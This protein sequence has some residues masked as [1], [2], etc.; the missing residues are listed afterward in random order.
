[1]ARAVRVGCG[2][3]S[4]LAVF[5]YN[6]L[7]SASDACNTARRCMDFT[8]PYATVLLPEPMDYFAGCGRTP[9]CTQK[10][11]QDIRAFEE[12][13]KRFASVPLQTFTMSQQIRESLMF[14]DLNQDAYTPLRIAAMVQLT[15]CTSVCG[16]ANQPFQERNEKQIVEEEERDYTKDT[17][18]AI[19]GVAANNTLIVHKYCIP[20]ALGTGVYRE[21]SETWSVWYSE[22]WAG[23]V[24]DLKFLDSV[25]GDTLLAFRDARGT[26]GTDGQQGAQFISV[27]PRAIQIEES[28]YHA[29]YETARDRD[30][31]LSVVNIKTNFGLPG[32]VLGMA[33]MLVLPQGDLSGKLPWLFLEI[34][35]APPPDPQTGARQGSRE[36]IVCGRINVDT[37][38]ADRGAQALEFSRCDGASLHFTRRRKAQLVP[39][40]FAAESLYHTHFAM[41]P[42][43]AK[44]Q[45]CVHDFAFETLLR[46]T[47]VT[48]ECFSVPD[49]FVSSK[50]YPTRSN[51]MEMTRSIYAGNRLPSATVI[52]QEGIAVTVQR[53]FAQNTHTLNFVG[54]T[55]TT[56]T[57]NVFS[58]NDP[59]APTHWLNQVRVAID[60]NT[61]TSTAAAAQKVAI[62]VEIMHGCDRSSCLGCP[63]LLLQSMCYAMHNCIVTRCIGTVV[64]QHRPLC[65]AGLAVQ[66]AT[67]MSIASLSSGWNILTQSF[68]DILGL[69]MRTTETSP[70]SE[71]NIEWFDETFFDNICN[72][73]DLNGQIAG[74]VTSLIGVSLIETN[75]ASVS[76]SMAGDAGARKIDNRYTANV[77]LI[78]N[79]VNAALYQISLFALY[80]MIAAQK[81]FSCNTNAVMAIADISGLKVRL[82]HPELQ[83]ASDVAAG[84]CLTSFYEQ[85]LEDISIRSKQK[86]AVEGAS[87]ILSRVSSAGA[88]FG[89][90]AV[91][92]QISKLFK[93]P[94]MHF[95]DAMITYSMGIV[96]GFQDMAQ[97]R[98][99]RPLV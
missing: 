2:A 34:I 66:S 59:D 77:A 95:L 15:D 19:S 3:F 54:K 97:V 98:T 26:V 42:T 25:T 91:G 81:A 85:E 47:E 27:H 28:L 22:A 86:S 75:R 93:G 65:N 11:Y 52:S 96:S 1:M 53:T 36:E 30:T 82:G 13:R 92:M 23:T 6:S 50:K 67:Q 61:A 58:T 10:C 80:P 14:T 70:G 94:G 49:D 79:G 38:V 41:F 69:S 68:T 74:I 9:S 73:K 4:I 17:C 60:G 56:H 8:N 76:G 37:I 44:T 88:Q 64:N 32:T 7:A 62:D 16:G 39:V 89:T 90:R 31:R 71:I 99:Q 48:E 43:R 72:A 84:T 21:P 5:F 12:E 46:F 51:W 20:K 33:D 87:E 40:A 24:V 55:Q 83:R 35:L 63:S 45:F 18:I 29:Q 57:L 78:L